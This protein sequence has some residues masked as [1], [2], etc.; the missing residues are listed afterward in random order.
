M[1]KKIYIIC[2]VLLIGIGNVLIM[3]GDVNKEQKPISGILGV[4][5]NKIKKTAISQKDA[6]S[7]SSI[8]ISK[9]TTSPESKTEQG[10]EIVVKLE[11]QGCTA[12][13]AP[14]ICKITSNQK[15]GEILKQCDENNWDKCN[16]YFYELG[17][18]DGDN[19]Y[20]LQSYDENSDKLLDILNYNIKTNLLSTVSTVLYQGNLA[21]SEATNSDYNSTFSKYSAK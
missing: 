11:G 20:I 16:F 19:Q 6:L 9:P 10:L 17:K 8:V 5:E 2:L 1:L 12:N 14:N 18:R 13:V 15:S 21:S 4:I 3:Q 7:D